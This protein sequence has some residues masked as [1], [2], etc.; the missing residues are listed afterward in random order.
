M[1]VRPGT[2]PPPRPRPARASF[3]LTTRCARPRGF[4]QG[5]P[6]ALA[7]AGSVAPVGS[8]A[9]A[10][11]FRPSR[12]R[13]LSRGGGAGRGRAPVRW[14]AGPRGWGDTEVPAHGAPRECGDCGTGCRVLSLRPCANLQDPCAIPGSPGKGGSSGLVDA[15]EQPECLQV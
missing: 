7:P 3:L 2:P 4:G 13:S 9:P 6:C 11:P 12:L 10:V 8:V 15:C 1:R 5:G 14:L